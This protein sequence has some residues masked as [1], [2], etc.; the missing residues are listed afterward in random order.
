MFYPTV[1]NFKTYFHRDFPFG[2]D[3]DSVMD[4]DIEKALDLAKCNINMSIFCEQ[5]C[6][7]VAYLNLAAHFLVTN[8]RNSSQGLNGQYA[9]LTT[10]KSVGN[11]S[12]GSSVPQEILNNPLL[13]M[14]S[15]TNYGAM[16]LQLLAPL[17]TGVIFT[18]PGRTH[19]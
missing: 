2:E 10:S 4:I 9:W 11:V 17:L 16:Y 14:Y 8:L 18:V 19:A 12:I 5:D 6:F 7:N 3:P 15:K 1:Q 13:A